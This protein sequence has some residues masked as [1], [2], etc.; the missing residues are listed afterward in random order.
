[1]GT[2]KAAKG[3]GMTGT[4]QTLAGIALLADLSREQISLIEAQCQWHSLAEGAQVFD[5]NSDSLDVYFIVAGS[6]RILSQAL[7][8]EVALADLGAGRYFGELAAIDGLPRSARVIA[9]TDCLLASLDGPRFRDMLLKHPQV[10]LRVMGRMTGV[11]RDLDRRV[12][13]LSTTSEAQ[14]ICGELLRLAQPLA[15]KPELW[16]VVDMPNHKEIAAWI[17][18]S[19]EVVA[20]VIGELARDGVVKRRGM[21]L[22]ITDLPR[23]RLLARAA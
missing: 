20:Q 18:T 1:M 9:L 7:E 3:V 5:K 23:L 12:M 4:E 22:S 21:G 17:G 2:G 8:R 11:I 6:V 15:D 10:G 16:H 14:R 13:E 19:R